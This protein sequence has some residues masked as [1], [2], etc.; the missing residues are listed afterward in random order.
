M[1][2]GNDWHKAARRRLIASRGG[3]CE[4]CGGPPPFQFHHVKPTGLNGQGRGYNR[5]VLDVLNN[6]D[7]YVMLCEE[8]HRREHL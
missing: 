8:C 4:R 6:P 5:R 3:K 2:S 1:A 7:A